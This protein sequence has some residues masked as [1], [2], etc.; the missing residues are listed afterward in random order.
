MS[1]WESTEEVN[2][3]LSDAVSEN[4]I[5]T[6]SVSSSNNHHSINQKFVLV[7]R[8]S[9]SSYKLLIKN[10]YKLNKLNIL[11]HSTNLK[12]K[13]VKNYFFHR[14]R[15]TEKQSFIDSILLNKNK[16]VYNFNQFE[17]PVKIYSCLSFRH[18][19]HP[20]F[21]NKNLNC[22]STKFKVKKKI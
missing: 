4:D 1:D 14:N 16:L 21:L 17:K 9:T 5:E 8:K 6:I 12:E 2:D 18:R 19:Y 20:A 13:E 22:F 15:I 10:K 7:A 11:V 3:C